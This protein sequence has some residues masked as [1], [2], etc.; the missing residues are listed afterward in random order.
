LYFTS[1]PTFV[2]YTKNWSIDSS[3]VPLHGNL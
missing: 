3:I 1:D 2:G